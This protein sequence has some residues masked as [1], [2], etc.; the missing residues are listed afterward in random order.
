MAVE[1]LQ[2]CQLIIK[3][4]MFHVPL[5]SGYAYHQWWCKILFHSRLGLG[6]IQDHFINLIELVA[7]CWNLFSLNQVWN[8]VSIDHE[9]I[10]C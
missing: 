4:S 8:L 10:F 5:V 3:F 2:M 6:G 1:V 9:D 7:Y